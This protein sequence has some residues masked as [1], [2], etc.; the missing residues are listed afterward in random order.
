M[1]EAHTRDLRKLETCQ[2]NR[3]LFPYL[4]IRISIFGRVL[5]HII[6]TAHRLIIAVPT[7]TMKYQS[8]TPDREISIS[9]IP[10]E[11][12]LKRLNFFLVRPIH[13][14]WPAQR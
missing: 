9:L 3:K 12:L 1:V 6:V 14:R 13:F 11:R 5:F 7:L 2:K 10:R 8:S 4:G